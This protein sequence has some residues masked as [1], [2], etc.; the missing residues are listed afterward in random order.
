MLSRDATTRVLG[1]IGLARASSTGLLL[2]STD[3]EKAFDRVRWSFMFSALQR[4][5]MGDSFLHWTKALYNNPTA[6]VRANG[7]L[8]HDL[9]IRN[10]TRQ[11]CP[12]SPLLFA[13]SLEPLLVAIRLNADITGIRGHSSEHKV[14]AYADDLLFLV[15]DP[16]SSLPAIVRTLDDYGAMAGYRINRDKSE[17]LNIS[18]HPTSVSSIRR[19]YPFRHCPEQMKYLGVWLAATS[20]QIFELNF[21]AILGNFVK[22]LTDWNGKMLSWFGRIA[23]LKMNL[24][25]R[26]LYLFTALPIRVPVSFFTT[27]RKELLRFVWAHGRPRVSFK[28][29]CLPKSRGGLALPDPRKY[30]LASQMVR[31][32]DWSVQKLDKRWMDVERALSP[33]PLWTLPWLPPNTLAGPRPDPDPVLNTLRLWHSRKLAF[34]LSSA[35]SPLLPLMHNPGLPSGVLPSLRD[36]MSDTGRLRALDLPPDGRLDL[37]PRSTAAGPLSLLE[38]FNFAQI[39]SYLRSLN[40][41]YSLSRPL[42][43]FELI[44]QTSLP[45]PRGVSTI[46]G[47]ILTA[48]SE[49]PSFVS[50]WEEELGTTFT[51]AQ[52]TNTFTLVHKGCGANRVQ[53]TSYK[54]LSFWYRTPSFLHRLF[55]QTPSVCWRC[56][57]SEGTFL[58][59]WWSCPPLMGF[60]RKIHDAILRVTGVDLSLSPACFLLFHIALPLK[61]LKRSV[62]MS[63]LLAARSLIPILWRTDRTPSIEEWMGRVEA[64]RSL[65]HREMADRGLQAEFATKWYY[66]EDSAASLRS[67]LNGNQLAHS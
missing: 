12:L 1:A 53:E 5:G 19:T 10:G 11:G 21:L 67:E 22:D 44:C 4:T 15:T 33:R 25:P 61:N 65:D 38:Q 14:S 27:L 23:V 13:I 3:A 24:L 31:I 16:D 48:D 42:L 55:P 50:R 45:L 64:L 66:W 18:L 60:W 63:M 32:V 62:L 9:D 39:K 26:L 29:L 51:S 17:F 40:C 20:R 34:G 57:N 37:S 47:I 8:S 30:Y 46:Y 52:W 36:R 2:L 35:L 54:I 41:G 59:I 43:P 56:N 49:V 58:H 7:A 28:V 6:R